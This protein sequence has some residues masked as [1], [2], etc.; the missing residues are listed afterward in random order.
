MSDPLPHRADPFGP[1]V[2]ASRVQARLDTLAPADPVPGAEPIEEHDA[3]DRWVA[4][5]IS[6]VDRL[7]RQ[8]RTLRDQLDQVFDDLEDRLA[9]AETRIGVAEARASVAEARA[10]VAETRAAD[11]EARADDAHRRVDELLVE[12]QRLAGPEPADGPERADLRS[13][14][15]RL[16]G[17]LE[18]S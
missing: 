2:V 13:V 10:T 7:D 1:S 8:L 18:A 15:A 17:R 4:R 9:D 12:L 16:R 6:R 3:P 14:L 5:E 11:A